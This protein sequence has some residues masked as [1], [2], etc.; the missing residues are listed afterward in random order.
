M[1]A[2]E[3]KG[4]ELDAKLLEAKDT[5]QYPVIDLE[6]YLNKKE[7]AWEENCKKIAK[8]LHHF[9]FLLVRDPRVNYTHNA[10]FL[11][12]MEQYYEQPDEKK[13]GDIRKELSYQVGITPERTERARDHCSSV[14]K[15]DAAEK[16][17]TLCPPDL[18]NKLRFFWRIGERPEKTEFAGLNADPVVPAAFPQWTDVMNTWGGLMLQAVNTVAEMAAI[19]FGLPVDTFTSLMKFGPHLLAPTGSNFNKFGKLGTVLAAYHTDL[20]FLT[21]HGA[22]RFPGLSVWT[23]GGKKLNVK[24]PAGCLL[25]QA[26]QQFQY[27][28]G[29][30]VLAGFHEVI[31][32]EATV[33]AIE[34]AKKAGRSLW[35]VSSTLFSHIASD[36]VLQPLGHFLTEETRG[37][38]PAI[39]AGEQV[40]QEL[41]AIKLGRSED[42]IAAM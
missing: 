3:G 25:V 4:F 22:S 7:G 35:R 21:I 24:V 26:G 39:K 31:V 13:A 30:Y 32:S 15:M 10:T 17:E 1:S 27:L 23:R 29:G 12:M 19:G 28:S 14:A 41:A 5:D 33:A 18:D 16:P 36:N 8:L 20:N 42:E 11:D 9:G 2:D 37:K 40:K 34:T 38:Y 6:P